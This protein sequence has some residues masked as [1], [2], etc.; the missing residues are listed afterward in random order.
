MK[1]RV[2][3][4]YLL[5]WSTF[6]CAEMSTQDLWTHQLRKAKEQTGT[7]ENQ[8][9]EIY[10]NTL[11]DGKALKITA[12][13]TG[14]MSL[15]LWSHWALQEMERPDSSLTN[16]LNWLNEPVSFPEELEVVREHRRKILS[17]F[18]ENALTVKEKVL[19]DSTQIFEEHVRN[20]VRKDQIDDAVAA[21]DLFE[22]FMHQP[23]IKYYNKV[24]DSY[25]KA[26][27]P[28]PESK[29]RPEKPKAEKF[30]FDRDNP[31]YQLFLK[32]VTAVSSGHLGIKTTGIRITGQPDLIGRRGLNVVAVHG[33]DLKIHDNF[34]TYRSD[35]ESYRFASSIEKLP[36]GTAVVIA[37]HDDGSRC[38]TPDAISALRQLGATQV[39]I[40]LSY[41]NAYL[42]LGMKGLNPG[43]SIES[44]GHGERVYPEE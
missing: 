15:L 10:N 16:R 29:N 18:T 22:S 39:R 24:V 5:L 27:Q 26:F 8:M 38:L 20:L 31:A 34:D 21:R 25:Q 44:Y 43:H 40:G 36:Y 30:Y 11:E 35:E 2:Y 7:F 32:N 33:K 3:L 28:P 9:A 12:K 23:Q 14:D 1:N 41:R 19:S 37:V 42:L 13:K 17:A 4:G 6:V